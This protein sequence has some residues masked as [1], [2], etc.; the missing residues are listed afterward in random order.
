ME[1]AR[2]HGVWTRLLQVSRFLSL[3]LRHK[4]E[5]AGLA[6]D[7]SGWCG[8]EELLKGCASRGHRISR[9]ELDVIVTEN[10]K[11]RFEFSGD[12]KRIRA[13][14]GHS[15]EVDL[16]Y[17]PKAPPEILYHGTAARFLDSIKQ[18]GLIKGSRQHVHLSI[19]LQTAL[20]V[21][22]RHG[23]PVVIP[24]RAGDMYRAGIRFYLTPNEVWLVDEVPPECLRFDDLLWG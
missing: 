20:K 1:Q 4:P 18:M 2:Y 13:S 17:D 11:K 21:G 15:V 14:Q 22:E 19:L 16:K 6:L 10:D 7:G 3:V 5:V 9:D 8:V 24:V 23:R 12:K